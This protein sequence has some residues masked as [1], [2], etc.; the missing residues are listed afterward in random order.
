MFAH[1]ATEE[2]SLQRVI[3]F[4]SQKG[5]VA[6]TTTTLNPAVAFKEQGLP[7]ARHRPRSAGKPDDEPG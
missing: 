1:T 5:G 4:A 3:V 6:K 7:G 2:T